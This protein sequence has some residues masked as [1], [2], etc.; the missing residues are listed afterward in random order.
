MAEQKKLKAK[1]KGV[2][3]IKGQKK[4]KQT[5]KETVSA[6]TRKKT[7]PEEVW[8]P[9]TKLGKKVK[10]KEITDVKQIF[11]N[12][13]K[14]KE[15]KIVDVLLPDISSDYILVGQARG[16]FGGGQ[17]RIM[18][19]TQKKTKAGSK[20]LFTTLAVVGN[21]NGYVG[22]GRGT[23]KETVPAREKAVRKAKLNL[24]QIGRGCGSWKC[25]CGE[26]HSLPFKISGRSGSVRITLKPA[27]KGTGLVVPEEIKK[28]L[29]LAGYQDVWSKATGQ[30]RQRINL[31]DATIKALEKTVTAKIRKKDSKK[32]VYGAK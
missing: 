27:P 2:L 22:V 23:G 6:K 20:L 15:D 19:Q 24:I 30:T 26:P 16:K 18:R 3:P 5:K 14:I 9:K 29:K 25:T 31:V 1:E 12:D 10:S 21:R 4:Q 17:R 11:D 13:L 32:I 7:K 8:K 28:I